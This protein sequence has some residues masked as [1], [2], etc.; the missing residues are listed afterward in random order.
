MRAFPPKSTRTQSLGTATTALIGAVLIHAAIAYWL[1]HTPTP[2]ATA[3]AAGFGG[4]EIDLGVSSPPQDAPAD[5][6]NPAEA[7]TTEAPQDDTPP[8]EETPEDVVQEPP[9]EETDH[10]ALPEP[11]PIEE[12]L[13]VEAPDP[14]PAKVVETVEPA[15]KAPPKRPDIPRKKPVPKKVVEKPQPPKKPVVKAQTAKSPQKTVAKAP[16]PSS[17]TPKTTPSSSGKTANAS[18]SSGKAQASGG[19]PGARANY[20]ASL[21]AWLEKHKRYSRRARSRRQEGTVLLYFVMDRSGKVLRHRIHKGSGHDLLD[22]EVLAMIER[23][24]PLPAIPDS[25]TEKTLE[26]I[27]PV[28]FSL[29]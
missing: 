15:P 5:A 8:P 21:Q 17:N 2:P 22:K 29:R 9:V 18:P 28:R 19:Q 23:A 27:V 26:L 20:M 24:Q 25:M 12:V 16:G 3:Q 7:Q 10:A 4:I 14:T 11:E 6:D 13:P 1:G